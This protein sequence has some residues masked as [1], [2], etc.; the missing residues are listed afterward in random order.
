MTFS[1]PRP[2]R[3]EKS[4]EADAS[5]VERKMRYIEKPVG[6]HTDIVFYYVK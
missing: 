4:T 6:L 1:L 2:Q 5:L 3:N